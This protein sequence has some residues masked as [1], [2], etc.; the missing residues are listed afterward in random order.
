MQQDACSSTA[1]FKERNH[2]SNKHPLNTGD[3]II[4]CG[5]FLKETCRFTHTLSLL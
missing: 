2:F 5:K 4:F 1:F 3:L